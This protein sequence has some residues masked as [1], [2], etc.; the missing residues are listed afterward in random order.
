VV[1]EEEENAARAASARPETQD[2][3][4]LM[5]T[6]AVTDNPDLMATTAKM[7]RPVVVKQAVDVFQ[8]APP[9]L[10]DQPAQ[11]DRKDL[12]EIQVPQAVVVVLLNLDLLALVDPLDLL[13]KLVNPEILVLLDNPVNSPKE[14]LHPATLDQLDLPVNQDNLVNLD[15]PD[16]LRLD[17][18]AQP[19]M[20]EPLDQLADLVRM[21]PPV[22][23]VEMAAAAVATTAHLLVPPLDIKKDAK[24]L[25][26]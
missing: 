20:L 5:A 12:P 9:D 18:L 10:L 11:L 21:V 25:C 16:Q 2:H 7:L 14:A 6:Q 23:M 22:I 24:N 8:N 19:V 17:L 4:V 1:E 15:K 26:F 3:R 13:A